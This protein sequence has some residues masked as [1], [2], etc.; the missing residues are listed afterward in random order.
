VVVLLAA[1]ADPRYANHNGT[2]ALDIAK[3]CSTPD[4]RAARGQD[5]NTKLNQH[6][7]KTLANCYILI[8]AYIKN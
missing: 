6:L 4:R 2:T 5:S 8:T 3:L 7:H 1:G